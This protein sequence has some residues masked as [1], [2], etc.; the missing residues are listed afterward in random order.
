MRFEGFRMRK[1]VYTSFVLGGRRLR[2]RV[3]RCMV[4]R[5]GVQRWEMGSEPPITQTLAAVHSQ[6]PNLTFQNPNST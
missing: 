3:L 5:V 4:S 1:L 2:V 6:V